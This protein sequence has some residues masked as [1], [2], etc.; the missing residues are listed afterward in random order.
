[1]SHVCVHSESTTNTHTHTR[2]LQA[3]TR[4]PQ[5]HTHIGTQINKHTLTHIPNR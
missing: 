3:H 4:T 2:T 1:M 5:A